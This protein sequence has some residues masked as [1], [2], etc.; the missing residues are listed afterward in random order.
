MISNHMLDLTVESSDIVVKFGKIERVW[1][2]RKA[3]HEQG[4]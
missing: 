4:L 1:F 2:N 3:V